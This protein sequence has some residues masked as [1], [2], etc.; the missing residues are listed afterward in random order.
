MKKS[1]A[2]EEFIDGFNN[3]NKDDLIELSEVTDQELRIKG[4][5]LLDLYEQMLIIIKE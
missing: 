4:K 3:I 1:Y 5:K 2:F